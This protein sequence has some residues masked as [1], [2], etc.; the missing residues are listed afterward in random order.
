MDLLATSRRLARSR[1]RGA[2]DPPEPFEISRDPG[3][4]RRLRVPGLLTL[5]AV[6]SLQDAGPA[7]RPFMRFDNLP[8]PPRIWNPKSCRGPP[9]PGNQNLESP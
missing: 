5:R 6:R 2:K 7:L 3:D 1:N 9:L 4:A 8:V